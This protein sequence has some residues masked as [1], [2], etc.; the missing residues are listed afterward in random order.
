MR[1]AYW[2]LTLALVWAASQFGDGRT[3]TARA[4]DGSVKA[5]FEKYNQ[6]GTFAWDCSKPASKEQVRRFRAGRVL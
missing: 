1:R 6:L 3:T 5:I 4:Q 2:L